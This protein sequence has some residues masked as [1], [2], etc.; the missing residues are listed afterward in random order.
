MTDHSAGGGGG[1]S[2]DGGGGGGSVVAEVKTHMQYKTDGLAFESLSS[3]P[4]SQFTAWF[5]DAQA[6]PS[7]EEPGAMT[8]T[9]TT[10]G[11]P[12]RPSSRIVLLKQVD[13]GGF[14]FFS[15]YTSRKG[16]EMDA[17]PFA[18]LT[19]YWHDLH[20]SVRVCGKVERIT[21]DESQRYYDGRPLGSRIG[22]H[23]SPQ[24]QVLASREVLERAVRD[25]EDKYDA[26][27]AAGLDGPEA[28][29]A[30]GDRQVP[31]PDFW[32][33]YRLVPDEVEFWMGRQNRL[34]DRFR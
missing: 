26:K 33:G 29:K 14:V 28:E 34:H 7:I 5:K 1:S 10:L 18:A 27:G 6:H 11:P 22:A 21:K 32:G 16:R 3:D 17:N 25:V 31:V 13:D 30:V 19:F 12:P 24:S 20:R 2:S 9:T 4:I 8:L 15:N 23:A